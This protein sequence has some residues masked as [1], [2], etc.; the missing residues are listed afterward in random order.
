MIV[1]KAT[2]HNSKCRYGGEVRFSPPATPYLQFLISHSSFLIK[3]VSPS[4][5]PTFSLRPDF[6]LFFCSFA[7]EKDSH[8]MEKALLSFRQ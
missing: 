1:F 4:H 8:S 7:Q 3:I 6:A 2:P 5:L